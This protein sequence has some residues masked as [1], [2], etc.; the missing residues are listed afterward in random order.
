MLNLE[1]QNL[2]LKIVGINQ[3]KPEITG[4]TQVKITSKKEF[5]MHQCR[6]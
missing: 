3:S 6:V 1:K 5:I 4:C 2:N